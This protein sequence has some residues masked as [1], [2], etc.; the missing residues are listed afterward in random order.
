MPSFWFCITVQIGFTGLS[1]LIVLLY[2]QFWSQFSYF[3]IGVLFVSCASNTIGVYYYRNMESAWNFAL[4][5][6]QGEARIWGTEVVGICYLKSTPVT[7]SYQIIVVASPVHIQILICL[8]IF[9]NILWIIHL[10]GHRMLW[11]HFLTL[12]RGL[13]FYASCILYVFVCA[14][15]KAFGR[16]FRSLLHLHH[17]FAFI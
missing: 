14:P 8:S 15:F 1:I 6:F 3:T 9:Y 17:T 13:Q 10:K 4:T 5:Y 7:S 11:R 16:Q 12:P 2:R